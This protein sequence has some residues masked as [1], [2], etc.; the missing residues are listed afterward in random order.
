LKIQVAKSPIDGSHN[1]L[2]AKL[3]IVFAASFEPSSIGGAR[4]DI[5][6][7]VDHDSPRT[8]QGR[9][10]P[11]VSPPKYF[12]PLAERVNMGQCTATIREELLAFC[13][14]N[15]A[16]PNAVEEPK[17]QLFLEVDDLPRKSRLRYAQ[18]HR[19]FDLM[20]GRRPTNVPSQ[21]LC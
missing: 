21:A 7:V 16:T 1:V 18:A 5:K 8:F 2:S 15:E 12:F 14:Q 11:P 6:K 17:P 20:V 19:A 9:P 3:G 10:A 4:Y 13:G